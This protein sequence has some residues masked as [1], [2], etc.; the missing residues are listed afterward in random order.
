MGVF[1][2]LSKVLKKTKDAFTAKLS[3]LFKKSELNA[4]FYDNLEEDIVAMK[5]KIWRLY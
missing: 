3:S 2:K 1:S 4:D 5:L